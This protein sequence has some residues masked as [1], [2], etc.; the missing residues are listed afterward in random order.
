MATTAAPSTMPALRTASSG[1]GRP[2]VPDAGGGRVACVVAEVPR[3]AAEGA[4]NAVGQAGVATVEDLTKDE[5]Q[6]LDDLARNALLGS[7]G[8]EV[9]DR[10]RYVADLA[11]HRPGDFQD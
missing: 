3:L 5:G 8:G 9:L 1:P 6:H 10:D 11:A 7:S 2:R 4:L